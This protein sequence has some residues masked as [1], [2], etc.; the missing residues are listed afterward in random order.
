MGS[1]KKNTIASERLNV[2]NISDV[3][4]EHLHRYALSTDLVKN[5]IVLDIASGEGYGSYMLSK[6]A[7]KVIGVDID[8][9]SILNSREKYI[10]G[11]LEFIQGSTSNIPLSNHSVDVIISYETIEHHNEH[12]K[13]MLEIKRVLKPGGK[14]LISSP[15]KLNYSDKTGHINEFHVKELYKDEFVELISKHFL[16]YSIMYQKFISASIIISNNSHSDF[17]LYQGDFEKVSEYDFSANA[18]YI[19]C[20]ASDAELPNINSS[21]FNSSIDYNE[22]IDKKIKLVQQSLSFK[23]GNFLLIPITFIKNAFFSK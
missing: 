7:N 17:K 14:L 11:N 4:I 18:M 15:D 23:I 5:K 21:I 13:M 22:L 6:S 3:S 2:E 16:N 1:I 20:L 9:A 12:N 19:L 10:G 8:G